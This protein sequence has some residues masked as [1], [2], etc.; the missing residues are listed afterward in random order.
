VIAQ[1][2][3]QYCRKRVGRHIRFDKTFDQDVL[4]CEKCRRA[5]YPTPEEEAADD[6]EMERWDEFQAELGAGCFDL[7]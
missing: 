7:P 1:A 4:L 6:L 2:K 3:C 5:F